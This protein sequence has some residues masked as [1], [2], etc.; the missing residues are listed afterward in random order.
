MVY[1]YLNFSFNSLLLYFKD[2]RTG[3]QVKSYWPG[4]ERS[5][6]CTEFISQYITIILL[7]TN[8]RYVKQKTLSYVIKS[9][10]CSRHWVLY[11]KLFL[12]FQTILPCSVTHDEK[13]CWPAMDL[14]FIDT[15]FSPQLY[16]PDTKHKVYTD[17]V[18]KYQFIPGYCRPD[19]TWAT[20]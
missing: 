14:P 20:C 11:L 4:S 7:F 5:I 3:W 6:K 13:Y 15:D 9:S 2:S 19:V 1:F 18:R 8:T 17:S 12:Y 10:F 16:T